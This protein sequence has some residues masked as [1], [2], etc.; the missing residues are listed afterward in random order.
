MVFLWI[1]IPF[2]AKKYF[3]KISKYNLAIALATLILGIELVDDLY[4]FFDSN[5]G[6]SITKDLPLHMCGL[7]VLGTSW[8][9]IKKNQL[10]FELCYFW[11][12]GGAFQA[13]FTPDSTNII[14]H[15]YL[16]SFMASHGLIV[17]NVLYLIFVDGMVLRKWALIRAVVITELVLVVVYVVNLV[18]GSNYFYLIEKPSTNNPFVFGEWPYYLINMQFAAIFILAVINLPMLIYRKKLER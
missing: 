12:L 8:A 17:L 5:M 16:F 11:G 7:S 3:S 2:I 13:I 15:F 14:D 6:W 10:V 18:L 1:V 9:L 4:R